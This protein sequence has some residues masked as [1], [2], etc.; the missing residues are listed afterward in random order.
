MVSPSA[1]GKLRVRNRVVERAFDRNWVRRA[2]AGRPVSDAL[3]R[4]ESGNRRANAL[5]RGE[6]LRDA[7]AWVEGRPDVTPS[8]RDFV[9]ASEQ[10]D[11]A[12]R[13][14][15]LVVPEPAAIERDAAKP[16]SAEEQLAE[17]DREEARQEQE[18][19]R[20]RLKATI[21]GIAEAEGQRVLGWR[22]VPV[23]TGHVGETA[24]QSRPHYRGPRGRAGR[25]CAHR[26]TTAETPAT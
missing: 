6:A 15:T 5:L 14:D 3:E 17:G 26:E 25:V 18:E 16:L 19:A 23:D 24:D 2:L 22:D 1:G 9:L 13:G 21:A 10:A 12:L 4:W 8:E 11:A 20:E 7:I